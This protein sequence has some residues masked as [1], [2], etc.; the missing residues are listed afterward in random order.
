M[1]NLMMILSTIAVTAGLCSYAFTADWSITASSFREGASNPAIRE[2]SPGLEE[3]GGTAY[4]RVDNSQ[5]GSLVISDVIVNGVAADELIKSRKIWWWRQRPNPVP[6]GRSGIIEICGSSSVFPGGGKPVE[7][8]LV[9]STGEKVECKLNRQPDRL[10]PGYL[11]IEGDSLR[12]FIRN[13]D[14]ASRYTIDGI[15]ID[16][17]DVAASVVPSELGPGDVALAVVDGCKSAQVRDTVALEIKAKDVA[18]NPLNILR[19][20]TLIEPRFPIGVWQNSSGF[21]TDEYRQK[22]VQLGIDTPVAD[23]TA[24]AENQASYVKD[25][26]E[27]YDFKPMVFVRPKLDAKPSLPDFV[28][29]F[30]ANRGAGDIFAAFDSA[31]EPEIGKDDDVYPKTFKVMQT[32]EAIRAVTRRH[33]IAGTLCQSR[34]FYQYAPIFD[35]AIMDAYRVTA[36]SAD[37][38]PFYWGNYLESLVFY[39]RDLK[40]NSEPA[41]IWVWGQG[42]HRWTE[43]AWVDNSP[44]RPIPSPSEARAQLYMQLAE[45]AKGLLWFQYIMP[46]GFGDG[47]K[48]IFRENQEDLKQM[49]ISLSEDN[50][51]QAIAYYRKCA[52]ELEPAIADMNAEMRVLRPIL[53]RGDRYPHISVV[54]AGAKD[55]YAGCVASEKALVVFVVNLDYEFNPRGYIFRP[56]EQVKLTVECPEWLTDVD[57]AWLIWG[58]KHESIPLTVEAMNLCFAVPYLEDGAIIVIGPKSLEKQLV[59]SKRSI[60]P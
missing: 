39:T 33:P 44:G 50:I 40:L 45:G 30:L 46:D 23:I 55:T 38:P 15:M 41:P 13:D 35:V 52:E 20:V 6:N 48:K 28:T 56:R 47:Y 27:K 8:T 21:A 12:L 54:S 32:T 58:D 1:V 7:I 5:A 60:L 37:D 11:Y 3:M 57:S 49:G 25:I 9:A 24:V 19:P 59:M 2:K 29:D 42:I 26:I 14:P 36:P 17:T 31:E 51:G 53:S 22:L 4:L 16:G 18:G 34:K 43:R 10:V